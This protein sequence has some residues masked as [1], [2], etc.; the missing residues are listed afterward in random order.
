M[1]AQTK[2]Q[3]IP[4][5]PRPSGLALGD[6]QYLWGLVLLEIAALLVLRQAFR[7]SHGG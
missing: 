5:M 7:R 3:T 4:A 1:P 2:D 6:E